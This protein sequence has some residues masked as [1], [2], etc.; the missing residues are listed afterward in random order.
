M[1]VLSGPKNQCRFQFSDSQLYEYHGLTFRSRTEIKIFEALLRR[2]V[3]VFPLPVAALGEAANYREPDFVLFYKGRSGILEIHGDRFHTPETAA[4]EHER[5]RRF[6]DLGVNEYEI[7]DAA[8]CYNE[9]D[10]VVNDFLAR[11]ARG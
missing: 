6:I 4:Q 10:R 2:R 3:L 5:R 11:L 8:G 7:Y 9:P 1:D